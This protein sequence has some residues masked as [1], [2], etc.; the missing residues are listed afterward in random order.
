MTTQWF[1]ITTNKGWRL[2]PSSIFKQYLQQISSG[3][4]QPEAA[5]S[6]TIDMPGIIMSDRNYQTIELDG[7][8]IEIP[9]S[10]FAIIHEQLARA[11]EEVLPGGMS[12]FKI[13]GWMV[14]IVLTLEFRD[15]L[16]QKMSELLPSAK[17]IAQKED[18]E[19]T[20]RIARVGGRSPVKAMSN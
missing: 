1:R 3:K 8:I 14:G 7:L 4:T 9:S 6:V 5:E 16:L 18:E 20:R 12:I 11:S 19:Y 10:D 17:L 13:R 2:F 15:Q